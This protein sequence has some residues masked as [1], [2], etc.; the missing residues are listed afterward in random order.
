MSAAEFA[1]AL[2][3]SRQ[4]VHQLR[5]TRGFPEPLADLRGGE[6]W[7]A[8]AIRRFAAEWNRPTG[9]SPRRG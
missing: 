9:L 2:N 4:S 3:V 5:S 6:V 8:R 1:E 7:D